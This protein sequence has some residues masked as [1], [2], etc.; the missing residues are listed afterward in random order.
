MYK[1]L[2]PRTI[3][4]ILMVLATASCATS[5]PIGEWRSENFTGKLDSFLIIG[6]TSNSER[7]YLFESKF[8]EAL[9]ASNI[10]ALTSY[11]LIADTREL[12]R[13][14]VEAA[15]EG[16][17]VDAVL[18]TR[19]AG[20]KAEEVYRLPTSYDHY[21][22]YDGYYDNALQETNS[23]YYSEYNLLSLETNVYDVA[24]RELVWS[25]QS[26]AIDA[27]ERGKIIESQIQLTIDTL[28]RHGM[29][30]PSP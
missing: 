5:K 19:L 6:A 20:V 10:T 7:R 4:F 2:L 22:S 16:K 11:K 1:I 28:R 24:S 29:I 14:T 8:V 26:E 15:I 30:G 12:S 9:A 3:V 23:G 21:S 18:V 27:S 13:E 17:N 25:M